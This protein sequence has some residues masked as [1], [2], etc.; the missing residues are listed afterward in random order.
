M[1]YKPNAAT[2]AALA[3]SRSG[4]KLTPAEQQLLVK[5]SQAI[6]ADTKATGITPSGVAAASSGG[7]NLDPGSVAVGYNNFIQEEQQRRASGLKPRALPV[8]YASIARFN[9]PL[10][11]NLNDPTAYYT[12]ASGTAGYQDLINNGV[13]GSDGQLLINGQPVGSVPAGQ[14]MGSNANLV[15]GGAVTA[16]KTASVMGVQSTGGKGYVSAQP[17]TSPNK[18]NFT[19]T[20]PSIPNPPIA[21]NPGIP[22][23]PAQPGQGGLNVTGSTSSNDLFPSAPVTYTSPSGGVGGTGSE[24]GRDVQKLIAEAELQKS[25]NKQAYDS[26]ATQRKQYL[27]ELSDLLIKQQQAQ[28]NDQMPGIYEDLNTRGLLRSSALGEKVGLEASKLARQT[29]EQLALQGLTDRNNALS[30]SGKIEDQYLAGRNAAI[31]RGFSVE[32]F[33]RQA[34][35]S[36]EIG[37]AVTPVAQNGG[38]GGQALGGALGGASIGANFGPAG[39]GIGGV[40]GGVLGS[41]SG[42]SK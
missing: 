17:I 36:R 1:A 21:V 19:I 11:Y 15:G 37:T 26:Q 18:G 32:D 12:P 28:L 39:A 41:A 35:L 8:Q 30:Q 13:I 4:Q 22:S 25:L 42:K 38:K 20:D 24:A 5:H 27:S 10:S 31:Q 16:G 40:I 3:K 6:I 34:D 2:Q 33:N 29:S 7:S 9:N 14:N 23:Q